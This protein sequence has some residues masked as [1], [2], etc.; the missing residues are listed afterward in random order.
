MD[1]NTVQLLINHRGVATVT[2]NRPD[3][4]N[5]FDDAIIAE[6]RQAFDELADR[7]DVRVVVLASEGKSLSLIHI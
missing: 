7:E 4:H 5:A 6:L 2:L 1:N 3:K